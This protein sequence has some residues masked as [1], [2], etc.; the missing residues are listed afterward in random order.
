MSLD[1]NFVAVTYAES[2]HPYTLYP[3]RLTRYLVDRFHLKPGARLLDVGCGRGEFLKG[4]SLAGLQ[5]CGLD[6]SL[7]AKALCPE[8]RVEAIQLESEPFPFEDDG[9][10]VV[11]C[12]SVIEHFYYPEKIVQ[13]IH[14]VLKPGGIA[15]IMTP[16]W[17]SQFKIFYEDFTH[18]TPFTEQSLSEILCV[19]NFNDVRVEKFRQLPFLWKRPFLSPLCGLIAAVTP[20]SSVKI[21][22]FSKEIMLLATGTKGATGGGL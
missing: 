11:F 22:R 12:K 16:D 8:G 17:V 5:V 3:N 10:D 15:I 13:E 14:R 1:D 18:R 19:F 6:R 7:Q 2:H 4:F 20:R 21:I 9:F